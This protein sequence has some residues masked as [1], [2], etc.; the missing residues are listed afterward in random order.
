MK[1]IVLYT[2]IPE[3]P[4]RLSPLKEMSRNLWF[5][6]NL[7][8]IDL[9]RSI[10]Q[11]LWEETQHNPVALLSRLSQD[12]YNELLEDEGFLLEMDRVYEDYTRYIR[13]EKSYNFGLKKPLNFTIAYF[14]AEYGLTDCL[15]IYSGGLGVLAGD[16]LKSASDLR[17]NVVGVGLLY[18]KGYFR[19]YL[20]ADGWQLETYSDNDFHILPIQLL[21]AENGYPITIEVPIENRN[22]KV[23]VWK[24]QVGRVSLLMLDTNTIENEYSDRDITSSLYGG[25]HKRRLQQEMILGIGGVRVLETL[26]IQPSV[27]HMNEGHSAFAIIERIRILMEKEGLSFDEA[28]ESVYMTNVFTT[29]TPVPAGIDVFHKDLIMAQMNTYLQQIGLDINHFMSLG[30]FEKEARSDLFN[31]AVMAIKN[32]AYVNGVSRLHQKVSRKMWGGIWPDL[33]ETDI[34]ISYITNGIHIPSWISG[35]LATLLDRYLG[36]RWAEDPDNQKIWERVNAIPDSELWRTHERR[37][38]RLVGFARKR[39]EEQLI[40]KGAKRVDIQMAREALHPGALTIGFAR[41]F[42]TYKRGD[43][44]LKDPS[45]LAKILNDPQRPVQIIFA[46][47]A[48]PKDQPGK[49]I[50]KNIFHFS[51]QPEFRHRI[52]F[53]ED[54][55]LNIARYLVQ[56]VDVWLNT[57]LRPMEACGTSGMKAAANGALNLS[58]LD[59]WWAE[60]YQSGLGWAI[61][62]GEEYEDIDYQAIIESQAIYNLLETT[63]VPLFYERG[64]DNLPREWI[65]MMK[66]SMQILAAY[67]NSNRMLEDYITRFYLPSAIMWSQIREDQWN[68]IRQFI[69]WKNHIRSNWHGLKILG[70]KVGPQKEIE[71]GKTLNVEVLMELGNLSSDDIS[72]EVYY[73]PVDSKANLL[74]RFILRLTHFIQDG[75][76]IIYQGEIPCD[77]VGRFGF[78]IRVLPYHPLL[79]NPYSL[80]LIL[81]G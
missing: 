47:K 50:I 17:V 62:D 55:D 73:G 31:M 48:H 35:D 72:V 16:H 64:K 39:L 36:K 77:R 19:Q 11:N 32:S 24:I 46:G 37:R 81:W 30:T 54:Y 41:R 45:R 52:V 78:K 15:P 79:V 2:V 34:P 66:R 14:S 43:L 10:D 57:P 71:R 27:Y 80:N 21:K 13:E 12:R 49:E 40:Q 18:Q 25:D 20:N 70:K 4:E 6:W 59:G 28:R 56:G 74:D 63:I 58:V 23:R 22:V 29:H 68:P 65:R 7:E 9:F 53:I 5:S 38:E 44:I 8:A 3:I 60:G 69:H 1:D 51:Q 33:P 67:F 76:K 26:G 42:A 75:D 61:G